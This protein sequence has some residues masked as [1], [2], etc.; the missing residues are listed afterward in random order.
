[1]AVLF[2]L[3][4]GLVVALLATSGENRTLSWKGLLNDDAIL[5]FP[6]DFCPQILEC[7]LG[8]VAGVGC[9]ST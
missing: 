4:M 2:L 7:K 8:V 5:K 9:G 6:L 3:P 1:M